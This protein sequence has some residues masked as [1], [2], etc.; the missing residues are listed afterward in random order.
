MKIY[1]SLENQIQA[2]F[3]LEQN[4]PITSRIFSC[5]S[6][7]NHNKFSSFSYSILCI[8]QRKLHFP[9][10]FSC[11]C[12]YF[13]SACTRTSIM[14]NKSSMTFRAT[15]VSFYNTIFFLFR[16]KDTSRDIFFFCQQQTKSSSHR[17]K[18]P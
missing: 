9:F 14:K 4:T 10:F 16:S 6:F 12:V 7:T 18:Y 13:S 17:R 3:P 8:L 5:L 1:K 2:N 11:L 15:K